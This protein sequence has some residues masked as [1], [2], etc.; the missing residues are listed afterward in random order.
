MTNNSETLL[1]FG[2]ESDPDLTR[3]TGALYYLKDI[4]RASQRMLAPLDHK[5]WVAAKDHCA[6]FSTPGRGNGRLISTFSQYENNLIVNLRSS[7]VS[8]KVWYPVIIYRY[9]NSLLLL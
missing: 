3:L 8:R 5:G 7:Q 6:K 4:D 9:N 1:G 2:S